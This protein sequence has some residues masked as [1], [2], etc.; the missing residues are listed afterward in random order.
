MVGILV[1]AANLC[2][3]LLINNDKSCS[4]VEYKERFI[5]ALTYKIS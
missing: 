2:Y 3:N 5:A 1:N 4:I